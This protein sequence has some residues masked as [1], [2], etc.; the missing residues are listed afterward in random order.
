[1]KEKLA[2]NLGLKLISL[3]LAFFLW[4]LVVNVSNPEV[5]RSRDIPVEIVNE[6]VLASAGQ[7]YEIVG[8]ST[9]SVTYRVRTLDEYKISSSDFRAYID[10]QDLYDVTGAVPVS[11][12]V[13]NNRELVDTVAIR[14]NVVHV[15]TEPLQRKRFQLQ[16]LAQGTPKD[17]Y[18]LGDLS[19]N[20]E[21]IFVSG[22]ESQVGHITGAGIEYN[23]EGSYSTIES[24]ASPVF[25]DANGNKIEVGDRIEVDISEVSYKQEVLKVKNLPIQFH[26]QGMPAPDYRYTGLES[27]EQVIPVIGPSNV[28]QS[29]NTIVIPEEELSIEGVSAPKTVILDITKYL[30]EEVTIVGNHNEI[31]VQLNIEPLESVTMSLDLRRLSE[32]GRSDDYKYSFDN[33]IVEVTVKGLAADL[34][35]LTIES[36]GAEISL[37][38]MTPGDNRGVLRFEESDIF[39]VVSYTP[40]NVTVTESDAASASAT[41]QSHEEETQEGTDSSI[42]NN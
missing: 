8:K 25:Y 7:T 2:N 20:P 12:D 24:I 6:N 19:M 1:M 32:I 17:G 38:G 13:V 39:T 22:P 41:V 33:S 15:E 30:P 40:F 37:E 5:E 26:V 11:V 4:L 18:A 34:E 31:A 14:P 27:S 16:A 29:L 42:D 28:L 23:V 36:L 10:L 35:N 3:F 9:V 21:Y